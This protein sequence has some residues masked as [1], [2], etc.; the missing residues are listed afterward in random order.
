MFGFNRLIVKGKSFSVSLLGKGEVLAH[1]DT[2]EILRF[3]QND[4]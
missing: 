2:T 3:A 1:P 4:T